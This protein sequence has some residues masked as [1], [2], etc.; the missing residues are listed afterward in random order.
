MDANSKKRSLDEELADDA[1]RLK[2]EFCFQK[3]FIDFSDPKRWA[4]VWV[5]D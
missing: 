2:I 3:I 4:K 5:A 1:G